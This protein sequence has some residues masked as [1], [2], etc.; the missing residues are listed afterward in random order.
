MNDYNV[1]RAGGYTSQ[2]KYKTRRNTRA[3][4]DGVRIGG[5]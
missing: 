5:Q 1:V 2:V 4:W 3:A